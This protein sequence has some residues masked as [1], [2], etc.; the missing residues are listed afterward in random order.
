MNRSGST[1]SL[2]LIFSPLFYLE[3]LAD[4]DKEMSRGRT[5]EQ[6]VENIAEKSPQLSGAPNVHHSELLL[7]NIMG[8]PISMSNR[9]IVAGGRPVQSWGKQGVNLERVSGKPHLAISPSLCQRPCAS[10]R[11]PPAS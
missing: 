1:N 10:G 7:A 11:S 9:P 4:L 5:A 3:T 2:Y 8:Q 6:V